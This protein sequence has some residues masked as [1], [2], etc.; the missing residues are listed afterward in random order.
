MADAI[1]A[2]ANAEGL[3]SHT[4]KQPVSAPSYTRQEQLEAL[5]KLREP[6][7]EHQISHRPH[8][9]CAACTASWTHLCDQ[10]PR[11]LCAV[12][13]H[14]ITTA[15]TDL[16]YVGHAEATK[17]LLEVDPFWDWEPMALAPN[18]LPQLD[19]FGGMWIRLTVYGM[20]RF[21]Y[22]D[23]VGK[24]RS[25]YA[26]K[27][28][29]GDAIRNAGMRFGIALDLWMTSD[30]ARAKAEDTATA[31]GGPVSPD[32]RL[33]QLLA[34]TQKRWGNRDALLKLLALV[35]AEEL[36]ESL[37]PDTTPGQMKLFGL[38]LEDRIAEL[39]QGALEAFGK[40]IT[41]DWNNL[42]STRK[43]L[44]QAQDSWPDEIVPSGDAQVCLVDLLENRITELEAAPGGE[45]QRSAA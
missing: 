35:D 5:A 31:L 28:T 11:A 6:F 40:K 10:H 22:G 25:P 29:I 1:P 14:N 26:V 17:R 13:G 12:C 21:G 15:H 44:T 4:Q 37:V 8:V 43:N 19:E 27:E 30:R 38:L 34:W 3:T 45:Y 39:Y 2:P 18:G 24:H 33:E 16:A 7:P 9:D 42:D 41:H 36:R 20:T 32:A 23:A